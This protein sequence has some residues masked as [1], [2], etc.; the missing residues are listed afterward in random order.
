MVSRQSV[1]GGLPADLTSFV[2][3]RAELTEVRQLLRTA[4][5]VT[6]TGM[7]GVGKTRLALRCAQRL[8]VEFADGAHCVEL[9]PVRP[10]DLVATAVADA[11][12]LVDSTSRSRLDVVVDHLR[13][14]EALLLLDNCEHVLDEVAGVVEAVLRAAPRVRIVATSR[15]PL[16]V[17][18][19]ELLPV[20][21]FPLPSAELVVTAS[22]LEA[23]PALDLFVRRARSAVPGFRVDDGNARDLVLI[24]RRLE[25]I[26]LAL[27][28]AAVRLKVLTPGQLRVRLARRLEVL[29]QGPKTSPP[30]QQTLR[31]TLEWTYE[32]CTDSERHL[33]RIASVFA[34]GFT[35]ASVAA[36]SD[37]GL[38]EAELLGALTG[39]VDRSVLLRREQDGTLRFSMLETLREYGLDRLAAS[40]E[41]P[42]VRGRFLGWYTRLVEEFVDGWFTPSPGRSWLPTLHAE[43]AN[44]RAALQLALADPATVELA[45]RTAAD[46]WPYWVAL[47]LSEG[48]SWLQRAAAQAGDGVHRHRAMVIQGFIA[49]LQGDQPEAIRVLEECLEW[50]RT[51]GDPEI[52]RAAIH[53][54][55]LSSFFAGDR[56]RAHEC[57]DAAERIY[58]SAEVHPGWT[59]SLR[60]HKGLMLSIEGDVGRAEAHLQAGLRD[61]LDAG[62]QWIVGFV[63]AGL[64]LAAFERRDFDTA[65]DMLHRCL[66]GREDDDLLCSAL[67]LDIYAWL[68][69][70]D[71][72]GERAATLLGGASELWGSFGQD[73][74]GSAG[75][76]VRRRVCE[77]RARAVAG[78]RAFD[79][80]Y[81]HGR[82]LARSGAIVAYA[83]GARAEEPRREPA[84][85]DSCLTRRERQVAELVASGLSN[86]AIATRLV[87]STRTVEGH[88]QRILVKMAFTSRT[89]V[90]AWIAA[91]EGPGAPMAGGRAR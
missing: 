71:G 53:L 36:V 66:E 3:R 24:C 83:A 11:L 48:R 31:A 37:A 45:Q 38:G 85:D 60:V 61:C 68:L 86:R 2:G 10:A 70:A 1:A 76:I 80:A 19:E 16:D 65:K 20:N 44:L 57:L 34:G 39:L 58:R 41:E 15:Q 28:L 47:S 88:V 67:A 82:A 13:D 8:A 42:V 81:A 52:E 14:R 79:A 72:V 5:L 30:R 64:A 49:S 75:F 73:L 23:Y 89:Q 17:P 78:G 43:H 40:G 22:T 90:A 91:G 33:W 62:E 7:G 27:E 46:L 18:G 25:G 56:Q 63:Y 51:A 9:A 54:I 50:A 74:Y 77:E 35:L 32:L 12:S 26:P 21:P 6:L 29:T 69:A 84:P 4:R 87:L 59:V 55:G